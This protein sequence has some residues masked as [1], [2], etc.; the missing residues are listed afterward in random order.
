MYVC[1]CMC[2]CM[3][4]CVCVSIFNKNLIVVMQ[5]DVNTCLKKSRTQLTYSAGPNRLVPMAAA[6]SDEG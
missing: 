6:A 3:Y 4:V 5:L 1:V 2:V